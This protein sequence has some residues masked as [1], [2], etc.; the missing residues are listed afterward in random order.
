MG[1]SWSRN[2]NESIG[3][4]GERRGWDF[5]RRQTGGAVRFF[6]SFGIFIR[7]DEH[8]EAAEGVGAQENGASIAGYW[9]RSWGRLRRLFLLGEAGVDVDAPFDAVVSDYV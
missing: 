9:T 3:G 8:A 5:T 1:E 6:H 2:W 4:G 7:R